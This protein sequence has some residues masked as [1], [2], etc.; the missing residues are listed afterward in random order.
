MSTL[1]SLKYI[2]IENFLRKLI[3]NPIKLLKF[4]NNKNEKC[5]NTKGSHI[6]DTDSCS[7]DLLS[8]SNLSNCNYQTSNCQTSI[9]NP[10]EQTANSN[11][12]VFIVKC[13]FITIIL[14]IILTQTIWSIWYLWC[15][16]NDA[17]IINQNNLYKTLITLLLL[18]IDLYL[19]YHFIK[20]LINLFKSENLLWNVEN[21]RCTNEQITCPANQ[22]P[23]NSI[24]LVSN[25]FNVNQKP[26][27][28][29]PAPVGKRRQSTMIPT[30]NIKLATD[31]VLDEQIKYIDSISINS[32]ENQLKHL[33]SLSSTRS[34]SVDFNGRKINIDQQ[35]I[36]VQLLQH[37]QQLVF[38]SSDESLATELTKYYQDD[39]LP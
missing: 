35:Q 27:T 29:I 3:L 39:Y 32:N 36:N 15:R 2:S 23:L 9:V 6:F 25:Y 8:I 19:F 37:Q 16:K 33:P 12:V 20:L 31:D 14:S 26:T 30:I 28:I 22:L 21:D 24:A 17:N 13:T 5:P 11:K 4:S 10:S 34:S 38:N 7:N 1:I 18:L